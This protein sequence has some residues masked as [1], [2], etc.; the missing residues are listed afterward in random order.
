V[1]AGQGRDEASGST[2]GTQH[3][4]RLI[5]TKQIAGINLI[6]NISQLFR[7]TV[8]NDDISFLFEGI[9]IANDAGIKELIFCITGS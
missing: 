2:A 9:Q 6:R 5:V 1:K 7:H 3:Q 4:K 8:R